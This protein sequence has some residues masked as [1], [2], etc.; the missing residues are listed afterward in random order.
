M[1]V[2]SGLIVILRIFAIAMLLQ[3]VGYMIAVAATIATRAEITLLPQAAIASLLLIPFLLIFWSAGPIVDFLSPRSTETIPEGPVTASQLQA[4]AFSATGAF[5][6]YLALGNTIG[7]IAIWHMA[8]RY[9]GE[10]PLP[11]AEALK[12]ALGWTVGL[13]LL[14]GGPGL[15]QWIDGLRHA[16]GH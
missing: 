11:L 15:R 3:V 16:G 4:V 14:V 5:I 2:R 6:L 12:A 7:L 9:P 8:G 1:P 10:V 13:Y